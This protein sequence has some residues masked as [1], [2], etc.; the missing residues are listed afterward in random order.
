M[1]EQQ[2]LLPEE[3][4]ITPL[5]EILNDVTPKPDQAPLKP[6]SDHKSLKESL[7]ILFP[8][9]QHK[10]KRIQRAKEILG[11]LAQKFTDSQLRDVVTEIQFLADSWLDDFERKTFG[12]L[13]LKELL[14]EKGG[15]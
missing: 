14:H 11:T 12:G 10:E 1:A 3:R 6:Q 13:T 15:S 5:N 2:L 9:Q 7:D 8:E 4:Y